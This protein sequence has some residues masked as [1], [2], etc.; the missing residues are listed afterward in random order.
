M[1]S[2][3]RSRRRAGLPRLRLSRSLS[4][5]ASRYSHHLARTGVLAHAASGIR[6]APRWNWRGEVLADFSQ[7]VRPRRLVAAWLGSPAHRAILLSREP[8][9]VGVGEAHGHGYAW[10]TG[11]FGR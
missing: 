11:Q 9:Y 4:R 2:I 5:T 6:V 7:P 3:N 10:Y 1:Q 8:R